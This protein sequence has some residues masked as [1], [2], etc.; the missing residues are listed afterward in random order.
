[1]RKSSTILA[2]LGFALVIL[3]TSIAEPMNG[4]VFAIQIGL[5]LGGCFIMLLAAIR[6]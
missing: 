5:L 1:M 3:G 2:G 4:A 6:N